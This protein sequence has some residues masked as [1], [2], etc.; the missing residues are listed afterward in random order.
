M[1]E[2]CA[3]LDAEIPCVQRQRDLGARCGGSAPRS[4]RARSAPD[5]RSLRAV[6]RAEPTALRHAC[7]RRSPS[8]R[9]PRRA[10][11][12]ADG[13]PRRRVIPATPAAP[14]SR[15]DA[16]R[17]HE[18]A[19]EHSLR[20]P[21]FFADCSRIETRRLPQLPPGAI[22]TYTSSSATSVSRRNAA[23]DSSACAGSRNRARIPAWSGRNR[24]AH[25]RDHVFADLLV[26]AQK[27]ASRKPPEPSSKRTRPARAACGRVAIAAVD[28]IGTVGAVVR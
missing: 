27:T 6:S 1:I 14:T 25:L 3:Q 7:R 23:S 22:L 5:L 24:A 15:A 19:C 17:R 9:A 26:E 10:C 12:R 28:R 4:A 2:G 21:L 13:P 20:P 18:S 11:V 8:R 16:H